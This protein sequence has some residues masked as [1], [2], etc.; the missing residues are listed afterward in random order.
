MHQDKRRPRRVARRRAE[1]GGETGLAIER[2]EIHRLLRHGGG[3]EEGEQKRRD[4]FFQGGELHRWPI[5]RRIMSRKR[6]A[7]G[8]E[9]RLFAPHGEEPAVAR[10]AKARRLE[11]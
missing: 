11:P 9:R 2:D 10:R 8:G 3:G 5:S 7:G 1:I 4:G 6:R